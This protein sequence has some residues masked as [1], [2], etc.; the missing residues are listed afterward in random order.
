MRRPF[1]QIAVIW[2]LGLTLFTIV[3]SDVMYRLLFVGPAVIVHE[4]ALIG[5]L[6]G[7]FIALVFSPLFIYLLRVC[8]RDKDGRARKN[9]LV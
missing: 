3:A 6:V 8:E 9:Q 7:F 2:Y 5:R 1:W 4:N